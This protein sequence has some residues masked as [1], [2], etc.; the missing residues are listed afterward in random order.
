MR[1]T[2][3][4]R[5]PGRSACPGPPDEVRAGLPDWPD[6][7]VEVSEEGD[8]ALVVVRVTGFDDLEAA[9][10]HWDAELAARRRDSV[11]VS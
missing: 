7:D 10:A 2:T 1:T 8:V 11:P 4:R 3:P 6:A 9:E 5:S